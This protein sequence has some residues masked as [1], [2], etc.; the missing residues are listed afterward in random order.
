LA[1]FEKAKTHACEMFEL[2]VHLSKDGVLIVHH[3]DHLT[4]CTDVKAK[5][6]DRQKA[7]RFRIS[8]TLN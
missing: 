6:P 5:F 8:P 1:A 4:R 7:M 3:D 2:D